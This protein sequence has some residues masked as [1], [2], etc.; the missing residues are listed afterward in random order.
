[1]FNPSKNNIMS[2]ATINETGF[3]TKL[4]NVGKTLSRPLV[5]NLLILWYA[6]PSASASDK[7]V[8]AGAI[9]YFILPTDLIPDFLPGGYVDDASVVAAAVAK[10]RLSASDDV[11]Q[12]AEKKV[13]EWYD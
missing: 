1:M 9:A 13:A 8:I 5:L 10:I 6:F 2:T 12:K 4:K 3:W 7:A 11:I